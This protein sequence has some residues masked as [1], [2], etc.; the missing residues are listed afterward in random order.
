MSRI[1]RR[2][3]FVLGALL[4]GAGGAISTLAIFEQSFPA[5]CL[6]NA[7]GSKLN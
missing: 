6:G 2:S 4:G 5:F 1:G 3:G 7:L